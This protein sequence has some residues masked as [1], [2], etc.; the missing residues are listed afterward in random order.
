MRVIQNDEVIT[1]DNINVDKWIKD[2]IEE[3]ESHN[4]ADKEEAE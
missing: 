4:E 1:I 3:V 2:N